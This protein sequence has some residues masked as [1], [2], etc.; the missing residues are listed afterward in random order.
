MVG[1]VLD[2]RKIVGDKQISKSELLPEVEK[3]IAYN[4][5]SVFSDPKIAMFSNKYCKKIEPLTKTT[6]PK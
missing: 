4:R 1:Y 5:I 3:Q 6:P 2:K